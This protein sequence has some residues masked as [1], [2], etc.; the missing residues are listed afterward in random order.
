[1]LMMFCRFNDG[2]TYIRKRHKGTI[3]FQIMAINLNFFL[4]SCQ[5][6]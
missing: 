3:I 2:F 1:M 5:K 6:N 4:N